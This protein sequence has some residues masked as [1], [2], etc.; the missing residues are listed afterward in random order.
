MGFYLGAILALQ[1]YLIYHNITQY[2]NFRIMVGDVNN[3]RARPHACTSTSPREIIIPA[4][5][6]TRMH[7]PTSQHAYTRRLRCSTVRLTTRA[8]ASAR[9]H[10]HLRLTGACAPGPRLRTH[11]PHDPHAGA[12][13]STGACAPVCAARPHLRTRAART[14][15]SVHGATAR[16]MAELPCGRWHAQLGRGRAVRG[17]EYGA[18]CTKHIHW[19][20]GG[21]EASGGALWQRA[22]ARAVA[23]D[24][25][26]A[27]W[28]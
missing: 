16:I 18:R 14:H 2:T 4:R 1:L 27:C 22:V 8:R 15:I 12:G 24:G 25:A 7:A 10:R 23:A 11:G 6:R 20:V 19:A 17:A 26:H 3:A 21:G 13:T 5:L 28:T 9:T